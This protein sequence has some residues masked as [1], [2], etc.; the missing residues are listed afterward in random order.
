MFVVKVERVIFYLLLLLLPTQLGKHFWPD[1]A[2]VAGIRVDYLSPTLYVTDIVIGLLFVCWLIN[3]LQSANSTMQN[4][5]AK[6]KVFNF[7]FL[8]IGAI[9]LSVNLF[10]SENVLNGAYHLLKLLEFSFVA[11]YVATTVR[12]LGQLKRIVFVLGIGVI[13][14]SC[15]A[16]A[17][18]IK[19]GS[20]GGIFYWLGERLFTGS[21][22]GIANV[23]LN[24]EL[25]LRPYATFSHPNILAGFLL[26]V[27]TALLFT[28]P[29]V[30]RVEKAV[31]FVALLFGSSA[32]LLT[33]SRV[34]FLL[35]TGLLVVV[36]LRH[37]QRLLVRF[38]IAGALLI[39]F[40]S[41]LVATPLGSRFL[42]TSFTE[43]ALVQ[44]GDLMRASGELFLQQPI[45][46]IGFGNF[47]PE[48]ATI[49]TP[50]PLH[51]YLQ[52][53][54]N[55]FLLILSETGIVGIGVF[56]WFLTQTYKRLFSLIRKKQALFP[57]LFVVLLSMILILGSFDHYFLTLQQG[58]LLFALIIG[59]SWISIKR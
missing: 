54:H 6:L 2:I 32:L 41:F 27:M 44:R 17:Q 20:L 19:Q 42:Q 16:I 12:T 51:A 36:F 49:A 9:F 8:I 59:L 26:I 57:R 48:L 56:V 55:I 45:I 40:V 18:F 13:G 33:M 15:L 5:S 29:L 38:L 53:V 47:L 14:Q 30:K 31:W 58:Q 28:M 11:Y 10:H 43:E 4:H 52:P 23:S 3:R 1:F 46:G 7:A 50:L 25:I 24:G 35:W 22:P 39:L 34:A 37:V 21:T